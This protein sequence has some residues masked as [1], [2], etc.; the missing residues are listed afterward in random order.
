[1]VRF[2][3]LEFLCVKREMGSK[4]SVAHELTLNTFLYTKVSPPLCLPRNYDRIRD[5][6]FGE[7][8]TQKIPS[9][10]GKNV[11]HIIERG[12]CWEQPLR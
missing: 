11:G 6:A 8:E 2:M 5:V 7:R 1:M 12:L 10:S 3:C 4:Q 9:S